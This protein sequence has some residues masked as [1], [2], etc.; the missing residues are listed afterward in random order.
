ME[1]F[2]NTVMQ[3]MDNM[4]PLDLIVRIL[5]ALF[6]AFAIIM[7][8]NAIQLILGRLLKKRVSSQRTFI[9]RKLIKYTGFVMAILSLFSSIGIDTSALLGAAGIIGIA[10]GFAAQT[11]VSSFISGFFLLSEKPFKVG[12]VIRIDDILGEV[13]SVDVL[14]VK[15]RT[16]D[17]LY[18]RLPNESLF[19]SNLFNLTRFPIRRLDVLFNVTYQADLE[20]AR[21]ILVAI[22]EENPFVLDNPAPNFRVDRFDRVGPM[23][24]F[25]VWFDKNQLLEVRTSMYMAVQKRFAE[26]GIEI[27]YEK[28]DVK[29]AGKP[30][31]V[32]GD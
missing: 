22:A 2:L 20:K 13:L 3:H 31:E 11:T 1:Y 16:F 9:I 8:F 25:T 27:P 32:G 4:M 29:V 28:L 7:L 12:D 26:E 10:V 23:I 19:K 17:N 21:D 5:G 18:V 6:T 24:N 15:V 14:S 30:L